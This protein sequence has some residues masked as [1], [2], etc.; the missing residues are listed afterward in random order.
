MIDPSLGGCRSR[1]VARRRQSGFTMVE[2][3]VALL[4]GLLVAAGIV[5]LSREATNT[6]HEEAR[7]SVAEASLRAAVDRLRADLQRA[8][9]MSTGNILADPQIATPPGGAHVASTAPASTKPIG[10]GGL[11]TLASIYLSDGGSL[12][13]LANASAVGPGTLSP[14]L[15]DIAGNMTSPDTFDVAYIAQTATGTCLNIYLSPTS[16][17]MYRVMGNGDAGATEL[18]NIFQPDP[19]GVAQFI[20]RLVDDSGRSQ[21]LATCRNGA[22]AGVVSGQPY[23]SVDAGSGGMTPLRSAQTTGTVSGLSGYAAGRAWVNPVQI[24]RWEITASSST[25]DPEPAQFVNGL[26]ATSDG[27]SDPAKYDLMRSYLDAFGNIVPA[28]SEIVAEYAVDLGVAFSVDTSVSAATPQIVTYAFDSTSNDPVAA[29]VNNA[30]ATPQRIR[31]V[32][33]RVAT[34][35]AQAD[36]TLTIAPVPSYPTENFMYRYCVLQCPTPPANTLAWARVRTV[37]TEVSLPNQATN[38]Y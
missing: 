36:R 22:A 15:I 5:S 16:P 4:A 2:L 11:Q 32:Y 24:V 13:N 31:S 34:R 35:T 29:R 17:A 18:A 30:T 28:T 21:Y 7:V 6:F 26:E 1:L 3:T 38:F 20:V 23:V 33:A 27:G 14:D 37:T 25:V 12:G 19:A 9:F 8:G 10:M